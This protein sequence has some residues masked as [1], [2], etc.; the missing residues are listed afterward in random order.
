MRRGL[1]FPPP[2]FLLSQ[3]VDTEVG[4]AAEAFYRSINFQEVGV[5]PNFGI[6]PNPSRGRRD[7]VFFYKDLTAS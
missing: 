7:E 2:L 6:S 1:I 4:T 5:I 3:M